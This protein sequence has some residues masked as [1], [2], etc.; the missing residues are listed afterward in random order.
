MAAKRVLQAVMFADVSGSSRLYKERGNTQAKQQI[1]ETLS[2]GCKVI[3][4]HQGVVVKTLGDEIMA[5]FAT[6]EAACHAAIELQ[7]S[8]QKNGKLSL[9]IGMSYGETLMDKGGDVFGQVVNN[10]AEVSHIARANQI[11][12]TEELQQQLPGFLTRQCECYDQVKFKGTQHISL[13]YRLHW[14]TRTQ[15]HNATA[16]MDILQLTS[17]AK[18][19][20]IQLSHDS[21]Q[22]SYCATEL[23][24]TFGRNKHQVA[25]FA[26]NNRVS[27]EHCQIIY[28]RGKFVL[29][30]HSTNGT[31]ISLGDGEPVYIRREETVLTGSG[32][33]ALGQ[34]PDHSGSYKIHFAISS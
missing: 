13:V 11:V 16:V 34:K 31:Y 27:R 8:V 26:D 7:R 19:Q 4:K 12:L 30:D 17:P 21:Q 15:P 5:R 24:V 20:T 23:P 2:A 10:A 28:R 3:E 25:W 29:I 9:R 22:R 6:P 1:D 14:E 33:I 32:I 18:L